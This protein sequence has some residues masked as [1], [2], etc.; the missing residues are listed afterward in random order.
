MFIILFTHLFIYSVLIIHWTLYIGPQ[1]QLKFDQTHISE[2]ETVNF[3]WCGGLTVCDDL[4]LLL[5]AL[6][7]FRACA[8][9]GSRVKCHR[10]KGKKSSKTLQ[11]CL[12][13]N[14]LWFSLSCIV[15]ISYL[16]LENP[17]LWTAYLQTHKPQSFAMK[18]IKVLLRKLASSQP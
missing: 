10:A 3:Y 14:W 7:A 12:H 15:R 8:L 4:N 9:I 2:K 5:A 16:L 1:G 17:K 6:T 11:W 18:L 13:L